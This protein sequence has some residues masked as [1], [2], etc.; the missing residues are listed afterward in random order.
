MITR[1][2]LPSGVGG[3]LLKPI[4]DVNSLIKL[5]LPPLNTTVTRVSALLRDDNVSTK[6]LA[7][8]IGCDPILAC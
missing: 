2:I 7:A 5:K 4:I 6:K 8:V 3:S 1:E